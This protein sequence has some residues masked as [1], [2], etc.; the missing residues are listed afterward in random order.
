M[1]TLIELFKNRQLPSQGG[2]TAKEAYDIRDANKIQLSSSSPVINGTTIKALNKL[3]SGNNSPFS[4]TVLEQETTG[5]RALGK[6]SQPLLYGAET[7]RIST[8][9]TKALTDMKASFTEGGDGVT[10]GL[11]GG[12]I[13]KVSNIATKVNK[14]LGIPQLATPTYVKN[15]KQ[16]QS[17]NSIQ[18]KNDAD[19]AHTLIQIQTDA[20]GKGIGGLLAGVLGGQLTN[21]DQL[22]KKLISGA[23]GLAKGFL[24][25][26]L[27]GGLTPSQ[28]QLGYDDIPIFKNG[29]LEVR[30]Y[31]SSTD[32]LGN[33]S[34]KKENNALNAEGMTYQT[35][36]RLTEG[37]KIDSHKK[38]KKATDR[39]NPE[40]IAKFYTDPT[41]SEDTGGIIS[42]QPVN[43]LG[44]KLNKEISGPAKIKADGSPRRR[45]KISDEQ[46]KAKKDDIVNNSDSSKGARYNNS[47]FGIALNKKGA[48]DIKP[49]VTSVDDL[50]SIVLK[51]ESVKQNKAVNFVSTITGLGESFSP[52]WSSNK[53]IGNPFNFYT[54]EGIERSVSFSFKVF[55]LN[56]SEH[57][58]AWGKLNFLTSLVYPQAYEGEAGYITAPFL[59]LTIG[60]MYKRKEG[61]IES[62]S[63]GIDDSTPWNTE[64]TYESVGGEIN[65]KGYRLPRIINVETT[66]KF[67]ETRNNTE[68]GKYPF[69][70]ESQNV[71]SEPAAASNGSSVFNNLA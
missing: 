27:I 15:Q 9:T 21:P 50:D 16:L 48:Y 56:P 69:S 46:K 61:F 49:D 52:G 60:D 51:F 7:L 43:S 13:S 70:L 20:K 5:I 2:Q 34:L 68:K 30:N 41:K 29:V 63:Y 59:K 22:K 44:V 40:Y 18:G 31:G 4:E 6:L 1:P 24:R 36:L 37:P 26:K 19:Y 62:L 10:D 66:F 23:I 65:T 47:S 53:F 45:A 57:K 17:I 32:R 14:F 11:L 58:I 33:G 55:S 8:R 12:L 42:R 64:D 25:E 28:N 54:Y 71:A 35:T 67:I 38:F 3:R 39:F